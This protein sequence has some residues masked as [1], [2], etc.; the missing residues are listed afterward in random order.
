MSNLSRR[1][2]ITL[3]VVGSILVVLVAVG[4][5]GLVTGAPT[6]TAPAGTSPSGPVATTAG[7]PALL[8]EPTPLA[9]TDNPVAYARSVATALFVW[10]SM[11]GLE[12]TDH[13]RSILLDADPS[14]Y[15]INGLVADLSNYLP[16][17]AIWQQLRTYE[18]RQWITIHSAVV[19]ESWA[20][21]AASAPDLRDG[22]YAV[23]IDGTR[24]RA[25]TWFDQEHASE[26]PVAFTVFVGCP[27]S[28]QRCHLLRVSRLDAPLR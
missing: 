10:D 6:T 21:I 8:P 17:A 22:T 28:F 14:G 4:I 9:E 3:A 24:H 20:G 12:P 1:L 5:F 19:P 11:S 27:P 25:G 15:E 18:T 16:D 26:R 2:R 13:G 7:E 23:T